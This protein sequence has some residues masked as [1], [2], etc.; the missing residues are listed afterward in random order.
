[1]PFIWSKKK[2]SRCTEMYS[3]YLSCDAHSIL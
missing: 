1:V 2:R 3:R